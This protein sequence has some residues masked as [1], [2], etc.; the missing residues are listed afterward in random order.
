MDFQVGER[1]KIRSR[2][3]LL[4]EYGMDQLERL[5][6]PYVS[7]Q[8]QISRTYHNPRMDKY[9]DIITKI[10]VVHRWGTFELED[11]EDW[12]WNSNMVYKLNETEV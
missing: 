11:C 8:D 3:D 10:T 4:C 6:V 5:Y 2:K 12:E 1:V 7:E 9:K